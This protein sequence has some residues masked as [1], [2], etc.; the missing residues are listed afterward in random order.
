MQL[1]FLYHP[2]VDIDVAAGFFRDQLGFEEAWRDGTL[3]IAFR[4]PE[5][6]V[7]VMCSLTDQPPGPM[8]LVD[9]LDAWI[10][11]HPDVKVSVARAAIPGG[12]VAGFSSPGGN[13]FYVFDQPDA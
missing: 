5:G 2:V 1:R 3:T 11:S 9:D 13:T 10:A 8:Y 6:S 12:A 4:V 7:E